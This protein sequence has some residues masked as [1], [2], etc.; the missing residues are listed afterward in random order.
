MPVVNKL[1][2]V[3]LVNSELK[4][5][6]MEPRK[7]YWSMAALVA[8]NVPL[9]YLINKDWFHTM[10]TTLPGKIVLALSAA[11]ILVTA[12]LM[13]KYTKPVEYKK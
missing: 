4:T 11:A 7:E 5:L 2:D 13:F 1:T 6:M 12:M 3:R 10:M 9:L 8:G